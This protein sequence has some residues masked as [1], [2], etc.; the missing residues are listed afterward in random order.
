MGTGGGFGVNVGDLGAIW[1]V[2]GPSGIFGE[3]S[4]RPGGF[5]G[6]FGVFWEDDVGRGQQ[7]VIGS[8]L[9]DFEVFWG[10][11]GTFGDFGVF[12]GIWV[13]WG[14][15]FLEC[16]GPFGGYFGVFRGPVF[17]C[18]CRGCSGDYYGVFFGGGIWG[19]GSPPQLTAVVGQQLHQ[20]ELG[21]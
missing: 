9:G 7:A 14:L 12:G 4:R 11:W 8:T 1:A 16:L 20:L 21:G 13:F 18:H 6:G 2:L 19:R 17:E 15:F 5:G 3:I 10:I